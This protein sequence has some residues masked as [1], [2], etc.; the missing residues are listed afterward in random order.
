MG[1]VTSAVGIDVGTT[2]TKVV[3][4]SD[5]GESL[6]AAEPTPATL[7][8]LIALVGRALRRAEAAVAAI[9]IAAMAESGFV[10][11][12]DGAAMTPLLS[13]R[14]ERDEA[15]MQAFARRA[16]ADAL[17]E[18]TGVRP[19]PKPPLALWLSLRR[20]QPGLFGAR[21]RWAGVADAVALALTGRLLTDHTLAGRTMA[22]RLPP[23]GAPLARS[24]DPALL[25]EAGLR[26][27]Q[28]PSVALPGDDPARLTRAAATWTGLTAG[29]PVWVAGHDHQVAAWGAGV[30]APG[31]VADSVGT[32][33][34]VLHL[35]RGVPDRPA[36]RGQG[37]SVVRAVDGVTEALLAGSSF[38]GG[39]LQWLADRQ[40]GGEVA[41]L[42]GD[43]PDLDDPTD[44][45]NRG[46]LS[47][48]QSV[49][50]PIHSAEQSPYARPGWLLPYP[51]GRQ[52]P[53]P[54]PSATVREFGDRTDPLGVRAIEALAYQA[55][56]ISQGQA[57]LAADPVTDLLMIGGPLHRCPQWARI[58]A[59]LAG[60]PTTLVQATE[61]VATAAALLA[62]VRSGQGDGGVL[63]A[64][65][66][67]PVHHLIE[68]Y[69]R[70]LDAF[71]TSATK[72]G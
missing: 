25:A 48:P 7:D 31:E 55:A 51:S 5:G 17:F 2:N 4:V 71:I 66:V 37:M 3:L 44:S 21:Q 33:E 58:K 8:D 42:L 32:A 60:V 13:W 63:P 50:K 70:R 27:H 68:T 18:A 61:P 22:Y 64:V 67:P 6:L 28:L 39:F 57:E 19:G 29:T 1:A 24:F 15:E 54:D 16:G 9:G 46:L 38:A 30:R 12:A 45:A 26:P 23:A 36:V 40:T 43:L 49:A 47:P 34:A 65:S 14:D 72:G 56:W 20:H 69:Q 62:L 59:T 52:C 11:D 41:D 35:V 10:V 53:D